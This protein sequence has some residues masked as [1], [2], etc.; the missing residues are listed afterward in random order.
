GYLQQI[1]RAA[2]RAADLCQQMLAYAGKGRL[3]A[4]SLSLNELIQQTLVRMPLARH[5]P[6]QLHLDP[7]LPPVLADAAQLR[8][9]LV[10]LVTNA[11]EALGDG[12]GPLAVTTRR[13]SAGRDLLRT[14]QW[15]TER[16]VGDYVCL[17]VK[18][19]GCGMDEA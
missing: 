18:D 2:Q 7:Q 8:Q 13:V 11:V 16:P 15:G 19:G 12:P 14:F 3:M 10:S 17:E 9:L 6:V 1:D 4:Q 5:V